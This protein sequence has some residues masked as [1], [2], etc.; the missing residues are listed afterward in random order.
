MA[1]H[2]PLMWLIFTQGRDKIRDKQIKGRD[3]Q[4]KIKKK[5]AN[6]HL[7]NEAVRS[8]LIKE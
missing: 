1:E 4:I 3:R 5:M 2:S 7:Q 6:M 8:M